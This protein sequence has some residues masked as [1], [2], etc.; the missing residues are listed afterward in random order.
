MET[1]ITDGNKTNQKIFK[2]FPT[3]PGKPWL[4]TDGI[5]LLYDYV[6]LMISILEIT[7]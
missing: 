1:V 5:F 6:H 2:S 4:T 7:G 3:V